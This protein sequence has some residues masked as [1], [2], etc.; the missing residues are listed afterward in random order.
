[1]CASEV[2]G[3][4]A[5][6]GAH[7]AQGALAAWRR[8]VPLLGPI[9]VLDSWAGPKEFRQSWGWSD[10]AEIV[11]NRGREEWVEGERNGKVR[12]K[13]KKK[14]RKKKEKLLRFCS[15]FENPNLYPFRIFETRF[16]FYAN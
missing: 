5:V 7:D 8:L 13:K 2:Y 10:L 12:E 14:E 6:C 11:A 16:C 1:M 15:G 3:V 4:R 9:W